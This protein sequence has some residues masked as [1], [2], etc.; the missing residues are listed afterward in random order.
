MEDA[1][2]DRVDEINVNLGD[3]LAKNLINI[4]VIDDESRELLANEF[5]RGT[6]LQAEEGDLIELGDIV[7]KGEGEM[8]TMMVT[9]GQYRVKERSVGYYQV[10]IGSESEHEEDKCQ[11]LTYYVAEEAD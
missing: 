10:S 11:V 6:V 2:R 7:S 4:R 3:D 8:E 9:N 1:E 5:L